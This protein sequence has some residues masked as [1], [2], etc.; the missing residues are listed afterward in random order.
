LGKGKVVRSV[1][2]NPTVKK[3]LQKAKLGGAAA[4]AEQAIDIVDNPLLSA[5]QGA[6]L[7][8]AAGG[9][10]GAIAGGT[11]G[12]LIGDQ[13]I[14]FPMPMIAIPAHE[15]HLLSGS[16][17]MQVYIRAGE[18][19]VPTGGNVQDM[20]V[21]V[22]QAAA[23]EAESVAPVRKKKKTARQRAYG[24]AFKKIA[25]KYKLKNGKW[26]KDGFKRCVKEA[27]RIA[28]GKK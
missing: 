21:G 6:A 27:H 24:A 23:M 3:T 5:A 22:A 8:F 11:I 15:S 19:L 14:T 25:P 28:G 10:P 7:G 20:N 13:Y 4:L 2:D 16:P 18:T 26:K 9:P 12:Y 17:S 1:L